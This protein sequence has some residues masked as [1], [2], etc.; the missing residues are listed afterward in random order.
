MTRCTWRHFGSRGCW[1]SEMQK[2]H[3]FYD[4]EEQVVQCGVCGRLELPKLPI[5][6]ERFRAL[7]E[8]FSQHHQHQELTR[9]QRRE[10]ASSWLNECAE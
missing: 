5:H 8:T 1:G 7:I 2:E 3:I 10:A 6:T 4:L 9:Q